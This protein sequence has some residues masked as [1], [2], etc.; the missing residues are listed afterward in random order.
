MGSRVL[1]VGNRFSPN[2]FFHEVSFVM[3]RNL[4]ALPIHVPRPQGVVGD[5]DAFPCVVGGYYQDGMQIG[6]HM[7]RN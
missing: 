3:F 7:N 1:S 2:F 4:A 6:K 5:Q